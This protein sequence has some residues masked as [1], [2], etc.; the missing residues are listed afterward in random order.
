MKKRYI[1]IAVAVLILI[2][3]FIIIKHKSKMPEYV[4]HPVEK[5]TIVQVVEAS[6]T[7]NPISTVNI[8]T[9]VSGI[10]AEIYV[11]YNYVA[12]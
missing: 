6:G 2:I 8:G 9:Q 12:S 11:D 3:F 5:N 1:A 10:I 4:T 7:I